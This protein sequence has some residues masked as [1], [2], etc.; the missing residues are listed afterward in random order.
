M[1]TN[2]ICAAIQSSSKM[3]LVQCVCKKWMPKHRLEG[4]K[5]RCRDAPTVHEHPDEESKDKAADQQ[6]S[7]ADLQAS[8]PEP[9]AKSKD[10]AADQQPTAADLLA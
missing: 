10:K 2:Q 6:P 3:K 4:H 5:K 8:D 7:A 1:I 9:V